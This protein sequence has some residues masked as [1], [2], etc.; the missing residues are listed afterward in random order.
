MGSRGISL[1]VFGLRRGY[2]TFMSGMRILVL[3]PVGMTA[4]SN[5]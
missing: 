2:I 3:G 1:T 5:C 4:L